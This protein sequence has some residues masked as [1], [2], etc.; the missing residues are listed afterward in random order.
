[1]F[2]FSKGGEWIVGVARAQ[3]DA[4]LRRS[5]PVGARFGLI[6]MALGWK[7]AWYPAL[8]VFRFALLIVGRTYSLPL[9]PFLGIVLPLLLG[10]I[11]L[12]MLILRVIRILTLLR[13]L[14]LMAVLVV[15]PALLILCCAHMK[16]PYS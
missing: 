12:D 14:V 7:G 3:P 9:L 10:I 11:L 1:M 8:M 16:T 13:F 4:S 15:L 5:M 6:V 2:R